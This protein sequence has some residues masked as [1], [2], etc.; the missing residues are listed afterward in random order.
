M[1]A[2]LQD[3]VGIVLARYSRLHDPFL[4]YHVHS[5]TLPD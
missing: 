1:C 4:Y 2:S 5:T 3:A